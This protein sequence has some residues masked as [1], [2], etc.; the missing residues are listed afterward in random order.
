MTEDQALLA[1][2]AIG[3]PFTIWLYTP[4]RNAITLGSQDAQ[5]SARVLYLRTLEHGILRGGYAGCVSPTIF[6]SPQFVAMG[7]L[8]HIY[9][10]AVGPNLAV[11]P[12]AVTESAISFGSQMRNAQIAFNLTV[13]PGRRITLQRPY[14]PRGAALVPHVMR[15]MCAMSGIRVLSPPLRSAFGADTGSPAMGFASDFV[16]SI[17][18]AAI[19]MPFNQLFN[20]LATTPP[21]ARREGIAEACV[22]FLKNQYLSNGRLRATVV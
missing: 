9:A 14:D 16:A 20:Y 1:A 13:P 7:P 15:N 8:Y 4:L 2:G 3:G 22:T 6:S 17:I 12:T 21:S 11:L 18:S 19:S 10:S 5:A